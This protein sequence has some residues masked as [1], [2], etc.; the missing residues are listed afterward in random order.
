MASSSFGVSRGSL[1]RGG[2]GWLAAL[3]LWSLP[4]CEPRVDGNGHRTD[5]VREAATFS[6]VQST[7]SIDVQITQGEERTVVVSI[8]ENLQELVSVRV[9]DG[10]L[11][12]DTRDDIG[13]T[14]A[15]PHVLITVPKLLVARLSGSGNLETEFDQPELPLDLYLDGSGSVSFDG[16]AAAVGAY[17]SGSGDIRLDGEASDVDI[18]LSGSGSVRGKSLLAESGRLDLSGSGDISATIETSVAVSL[19]GSGRIDLYGGA[20]LDRY[21][22]TGSGDVVK[23]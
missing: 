16:Q 10:L 5:E 2:W 11:V 22:L 15:G 21:D 23:H 18:E 20:K 8:D 1:S 6:R 19:S 17:L 4:A 13:D 9:H 7:G 14:V 12:V 3:W